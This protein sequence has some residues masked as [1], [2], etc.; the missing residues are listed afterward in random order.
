MVPIDPV[1]IGE[2]PPDR[3]R[4]GCEPDSSHDQGALPRGLGETRFGA[5]AATASGRSLP[6][7]VPQL[8]IAVLHQIEGRVDNDPARSGAPAGAE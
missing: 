1:R 5:R 2:P 3:I 7:G 4:D 6:G 8:G